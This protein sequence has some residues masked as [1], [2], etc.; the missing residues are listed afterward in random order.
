MFNDLFFHRLFSASPV[1]SIY[2]SPLIL[3]YLAGGGR[4]RV[5]T[6]CLH[7]HASPWSSPPWLTIIMTSLICMHSSSTC[8]P[9]YTSR[10]PYAHTGWSPHYIPRRTRICL[11]LTNLL[12][13][14]WTGYDAGAL[15][16]LHL[17]TVLT[18]DELTTLT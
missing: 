11:R 18:L 3:V 9:T 8:I 15:L 16:T 14:S 1:A 17:G 4:L 6:A 13:S 2:F 7:P 12:T 5:A 10:S